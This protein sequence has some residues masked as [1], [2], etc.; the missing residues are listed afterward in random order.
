MT[1]SLVDRV[2]TVLLVAALSWSA[3]SFRRWGVLQVAYS[4]NYC[5]KM[6][7]ECLVCATKTVTKASS[8]Q[9]D[10]RQGDCQPKD[11]PW[12]LR[13]PFL[14]V[15]AYSYLIR[16]MMLKVM[17]LLKLIALDEDDLKVVSAHL[18]DAV[19]K[20]EDMAFVPR[21]RRFAVLLN[22]FDWLTADEKI[23][24]NG[25]QFERRRCA[26]RF[27][28]VH[29]AQFKALSLD[30]GEQVLEL[31]SVIFDPGEAPNG[32]ITLT[33]AGGPAVRLQVDCIEGD[34]RYLGPSWKTA[35][36]PEHPDDNTKSDLSS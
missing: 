3:L 10:A 4:L 17:D 1:T 9:P 11:S 8:H 25:G 27:E 30:K 35:R 20:V 2:M 26:L 13:L 19:L 12:F 22:R 18:Q 29:H 16:N 32:H 33:F 36:K 34:L 24:A 14:R 21:E 28:K 5:M 23:A 31:L 7:A 6:C 15:R